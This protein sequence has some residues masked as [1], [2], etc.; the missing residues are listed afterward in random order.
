AANYSTASK[1]VH[2]NVSKATAT[3]SLSDL[4]QTYDGTAKAASA[5]TTPEGLTVLFSYQQGGAEVSPVNAGSYDVTATI[6]D[7]NYQGSASG[8]LVIQKA[9][10]TVTLSDLSQTYDGSVKAASAST[11]PEGLT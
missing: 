1:T 5:S 7:A 6:D 10:A 9:T 8:T 4:T 11:T 2:I 3:V